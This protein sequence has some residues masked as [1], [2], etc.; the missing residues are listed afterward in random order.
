[1]SVFVAATAVYGFWLSGS[2]SAER[3]RRLDAQR[4]NDL[5]QISYGMDQYWEFNGKLPESLEEAQRMRNIF[6]AIPLIRIPAR[7]THSSAKT[8]TR[9]ISARPFPSQLMKTDQKERIAMWSKDRAEV[10]FGI[11]CPAA[12]VSR[13]T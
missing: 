8:K 4:I 3:A 1:M 5:Q 6:L 11:M 7:R 12:P 2:P 10:L 9:T 13:S